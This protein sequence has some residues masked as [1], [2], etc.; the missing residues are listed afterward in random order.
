[1]NLKLR[2]GSLV[3]MCCVLAGCAKQPPVTRAELVGSYIYKSEDPENKPTDHEWD[4]LTLHADG[5]YD[6]VQGGPS[7]PKTEETGTW[8]MAPWANTPSGELLL[9]R[10]TSYP[11]EIK[12]DEVRLLVDLDVGIWWAKPK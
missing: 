10:N 8:S 2:I 4:H 5:K 1:M 6:L 3:L 9:L 11:I 7:K 12:K